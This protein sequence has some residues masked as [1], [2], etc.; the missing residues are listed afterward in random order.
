LASFE[1]LKKIAGEI[2]ETGSLHPEIGEGEEKLESEFL[3][4]ESSQ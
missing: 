3:V 1:S 2:Y 4:G